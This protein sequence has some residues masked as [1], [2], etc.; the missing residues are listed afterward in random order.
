MVATAP[1]E[2]EAVDLALSKP[3]SWSAPASSIPLRF[4]VP[5]QA[6]RVMTEGVVWQSTDTS[7]ARIGPTGIVQGVAPGSAEI[8]AWLAGQERRSGGDRAQDRAAIVVTP[9]ASGGPIVLPLDKKHK[10]AIA[11]EAVDSTP[12]REIAI[13]WE[14]GDSNIATFDRASSELTAKTLGTT[15]LT[16]RVAGFPPATWAVQV[17]PGA[18]RM[19]RNRLAL[20]PG[21]HSALKATLADDQGKPAGSTAELQWRSDHPDVATVDQQGGIEAR[22]SAGPS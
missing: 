11:A 1:V 21:E 6:N 7:V 12:I 22:A 20:S 8:V 14:V 4:L 15:S 17:V 9:R 2:V 10:F 5:S 18:L 16:A 3:R 13:G 19:D